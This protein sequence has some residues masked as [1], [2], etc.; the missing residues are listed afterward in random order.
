MRIYVETN[1]LVSWVLPHHQWRQ[2]ARA[3]LNDAE[4]SL[5]AL[6]IPEVALLEAEHVV[7]EDTNA[8]NKAIS[9]TAKSLAM[10]GQNM[11]LPGVT[12]LKE[13]LEAA[14]E[15]YRLA[16]PLQELR[17]LGER[18]RAK[19]FVFSNPDKEQKAADELRNEVTFRG[20]DIVD[21][22]LLAAVAAD[23]GDAPEGRAAFLSTNKIEFNPANEKCKVPRDFYAKRKMIYRDVFDLKS[24]LRLWERAAELGWAL[25][26]PTKKDPRAKEAQSILGGLREEQLD[27]ALAALKAIAP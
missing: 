15:T 16:D 27:R 12:A 4:S 21:F 13:C 1:W 10:A 8:H 7:I 23:R 19:G 6:R 11:G 3:L 25:P 14:E 20:K 26:Q 22:H 18:C 5:C 9:E 2:A 24:A 17:K